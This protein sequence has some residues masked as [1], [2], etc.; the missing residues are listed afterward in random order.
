[1]DP[2]YNNSFGSFSSGG[3]DGNYQ[4]P[5]IAQTQGEKKTKKWVA[6]F[7][8]F[9]VIVLIGVLAVLLFGRKT[10]TSAESLE[11]PYWTYMNYLIKGEDSSDKLGRDDYSR[12][13]TMVKKKYDN[14]DAEYFNK[15][16]NL[17]NEFK[18]EFSKQP[19]KVRSVYSEALDDY[20]KTLQN[21][22]SLGSSDLIEGD[23]EYN[24]NK[25][26]LI[27]LE[28]K[29]DK[30]VSEMGC[31]KSGKVDEDCIY[32]KAPTEEFI[33]LYEEINSVEDEINN[34]KRFVVYS[35]LQ[36]SWG[37]ERIITENEGEDEED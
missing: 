32:S 12:A 13:D 34:T 15:L 7:I 28:E 5:M 36:Q 26:K 25:T 11:A 6:I 22:M 35:F 27:E 2:S 29:Y 18:N 14:Y 37:L 31:K 33:N 16:K 10:K 21:I 23:D 20:E 3:A 19:E 30:M 8:I 1:M 4:Q 24:E 17:F 9:L